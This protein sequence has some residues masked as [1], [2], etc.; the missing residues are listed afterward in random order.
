MDGAV[1]FLDLVRLAQNYN[2]TDG[3]RVWSDGDF[4]YDGNV[5][6]ADL[7]K[8][9]QTYNSAFPGEPIGGAPAGFEAEVVRAFASVP[10]PGALIVVAFGSLLIRRRRSEAT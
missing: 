7:V 6:F 8:L 5:D 10:E 9:A 3:T 1:D 4:N 2:V